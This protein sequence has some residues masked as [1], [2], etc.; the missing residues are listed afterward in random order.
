MKYN[1][2]SVQHFYSFVAVIVLKFMDELGNFIKLNIAN[3]LPKVHHCTAYHSHSSSLESA[4][5]VGSSENI[6]D[7]TRKK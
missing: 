1:S 3:N 5:A 4:A 6:T 7:K 2:C